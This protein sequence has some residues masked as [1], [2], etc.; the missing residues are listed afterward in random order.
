MKILLKRRRVLKETAKIACDKRRRNESR[1]PP[2]TLVFV[3]KI[4]HP[5]VVCIGG[6]SS[7]IHILPLFPSI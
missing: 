1:S 3:A 6:G 7:A 4:S 5:T 2:P